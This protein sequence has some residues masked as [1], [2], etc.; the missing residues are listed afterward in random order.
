VR[1]TRGRIVAAKPLYV[2]TP[3]WDDAEPDL[4]SLTVDSHEAV[5]TGLIWSTGEPV[6]RV[7]NPM[8]FG[9]DGEW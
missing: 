7:P 1:Y 2:E 5:D 6:M 4:Q 8:G 3:L 9:R